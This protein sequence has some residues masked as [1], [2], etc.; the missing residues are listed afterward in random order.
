[1]TPYESAYRR[2]VHQALELAADLADQVT[3]VKAIR[4]RLSRAASFASDLRREPPAGVAL[5]D[6]LRYRLHGRESVKIPPCPGCSCLNRVFLDVAAQARLTGD[7]SLLV[8]DDCR[9]EE[10]EA[11]FDSASMA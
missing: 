1:M 8:C 3:T 7:R 5:L 6:E 4:R 2:G 9:F 11:S 10:S